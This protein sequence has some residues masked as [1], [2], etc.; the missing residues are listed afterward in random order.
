MNTFTIVGLIVVATLYLF[1][2]QY[3]LKRRLKIKDKWPLSRNRNA[4]SFAIEIILFTLFTFSLMGLYQS[5]EFHMYSVTMRIGPMFGLFFLLGITRGVDEW[6]RNRD[7]KLF[8]HDWLG[9]IMI[10]ISFLVIYLGEQSL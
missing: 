10:L 7:E 6:V 8:Y 4:Y 1:L 5:S 9:S 2:S 3:Y